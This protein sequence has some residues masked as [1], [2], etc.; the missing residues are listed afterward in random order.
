VDTEVG[1]IA[2]DSLGARRVGRLMFPIAQAYA[3]TVALVS[4]EA[5]VRAQEAL[6]STLHVATEPGGAAASAALL[7][8]RY[9]P[10]RGERVGVLL[11]GGNTTAVDFKRSAA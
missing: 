4:D 3:N 5:I 11:C 7:S 10:E 2:A 9:R 6:W 1:G 8:R